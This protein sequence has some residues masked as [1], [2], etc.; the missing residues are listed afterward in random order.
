MYAW[1]AA[2]ES[3][4]LEVRKMELGEL[5]K[6]IPHRVGMQALLFAA[7]TLSMA[8][9]FVAYGSVEPDAFQPANVFTAISLFAIMRFPLIFLPFALVRLFLCVVVFVNE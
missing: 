5:R 9:C 6:G 3:A 2:Q 8:V 1:E 4:L 7:P